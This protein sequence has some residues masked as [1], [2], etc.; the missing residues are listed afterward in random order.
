MKSKND[1]LRYDRVRTYFKLNKKSFIL[2]SITGVIYNSLMAL[3]PM[4][5]MMLNILL[6]LHLPF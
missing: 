3:V 4:I 6:N 2:A 1:N 5:K